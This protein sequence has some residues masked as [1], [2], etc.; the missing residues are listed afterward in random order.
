[1]SFTIRPGT[2]ADSYAVFDI[3]LQSIQDLSLRLGLADPDDKPDEARKAEAWQNLGSLFE[4]LAQTAA[5]FWIAESEGQ[6]VG[7][8]RSTLHDQVCELTDFFVLPGQ[9]S[10]GM[11]RKLLR[12]AFAA[13]GARHRFILATTDDRARALYLK[14]GVYPRF[15]IHTFKRKAE[16]VA[17]ETDL[18]FE[19]LAPSPGTL[20]ILG[21]LDRAVIGHRR[22]ADHAWLL[23][24]RQGYLY[25]RNGHPV[26]YG[27]AGKDNGPFAL[28]DDK[29]F[30]AV[31]AH[32]ETKAAVHEREFKIAVP[33]INQAAVDYLLAR[34]YRIESFMVFLMS[35]VPFGKF[36]N[37][38][39]TSP[40][41]IL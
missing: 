4:H 37:Y 9:Q 35:D 17:V 36:E 23:Q 41:F 19:P 26:G 1:M 12:R 20:A 8:A 13:N 28:L 39:V 10:G 32:A 31:L 6:A 27:Y 2:A 22:D 11:G 15:P 21:E 40:M 24:D 16:A 33:L 30:A 18:E 34:G 29:D 7:F 3:F 5:Q 25:R 38:I 14:S